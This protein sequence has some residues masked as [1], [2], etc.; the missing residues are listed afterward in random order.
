LCKLTAV[1]ESSLTTGQMAIIA[2]DSAGGIYAVQKL[3]NRKA[4][5]T[6]I[7]GTQFSSGQAASWNLSSPVA[8][9]SVTLDNA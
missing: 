4:Y 5:L 9:V 6:P 8:N 7:T 1:A 3:T 2:T